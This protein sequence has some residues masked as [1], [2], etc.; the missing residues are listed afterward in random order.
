MAV[1]RRRRA[2][3]GSRA[4]YGVAQRKALC[5]R[6]RSNLPNRTR[7]GLYFRPPVH[8]LRG[9]N[10]TGRPRKRTIQAPSSDQLSA[11]GPPGRVDRLEAPD[12]LS[13]S[14]LR[15]DPRRGHDPRR[16]GAGVRSNAT[17]AIHVAGRIRRSPPKVSAPAP[18]IGIRIF[19]QPRAQLLSGALEHLLYFF[20][21]PGHPAR[22]SRLTEERSWAQR[23]GDRL[24]P[25]APRGP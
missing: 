21:R 25:G 7:A 1:R 16:R 10:S 8:G 20:P 2:P 22:V 18:S 14:D 11:A 5:H 3:P 15:L 4:G 13:S 23:H 19:M 12:A 17:N 9:N 6:V 24:P